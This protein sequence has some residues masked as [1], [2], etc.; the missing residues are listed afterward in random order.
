MSFN[1]GSGLIYAGGDSGASAPLP[2]PTVGYGSAVNLLTGSPDFIYEPTAP[3]FSVAFNSGDSFLTVQAGAQ[4]MGDITAAANRTYLY[5]NVG[6][7]FI[8]AGSNEYSGTTGRF[9]YLDGG[10]HDFQIGDIAVVYSGSVFRIYEQG[11]DFISTIGTSSYRFMYIDTGA[12][13][14]G[15]GDID[16]YSLNTNLY[17]DDSIGDTTINTLA[18]KIGRVDNIA[19]GVTAYSQIGVVNTNFGNLTGSFNVVQNSNTNV[20]SVAGSGDLSNLGYR[21]E[22]SILFNTA[23][24][25]DTAYSSCDWN[26]STSNWVMFCFNG[27]NTNFMQMYL[28]QRSFGIIGIN[29]TGIYADD[30]TGIISLRNVKFYAD[31]AAATG[32]GLIT[33]DIYATTTAGSTYIKIVP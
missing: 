29:G 9:L 20:L 24:N 7:G 27:T 12:N 22:G 4:S 21:Q 30:N 28:L 10:A 26:G 33:G 11:S 3:V 25:S 19:S 32:A 8:E 23:S 1:G 15:M 6:E 18:S 16:S 14:Y 31:D 17:I 2:Y 5:V 13:L